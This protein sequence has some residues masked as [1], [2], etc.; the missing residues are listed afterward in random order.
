MTATYSESDKKRLMPC[1][2]SLTK[3]FYKYDSR[4]KAINYLL[5]K[6]P[7]EMLNGVLLLT[8]FSYTFC[9]VLPQ[10]TRYIMSD[11]L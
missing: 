7:S 3:Q 2:T 6:A 8:L 11:D 5:K 10:Q 1:Q 4:L 9:V